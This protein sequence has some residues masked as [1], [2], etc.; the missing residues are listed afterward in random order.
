MMRPIYNVEIRLLKGSLGE[1]QIK[2]ATSSMRDPA[3]LPRE[4]R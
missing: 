1:L 3:G 2:S 4:Q